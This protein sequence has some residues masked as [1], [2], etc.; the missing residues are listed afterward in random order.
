M[1]H[2]LVTG[3]SGLVGSEAV[4]FFGGLGFEVT[5]VDNNMRA[6][7]FGAGG[8]T[9]G[10]LEALRREVPGYD[11]R[12]LDVRDRDGIASLVAEKPFELL[13]HA[14]AQP[15]HDLGARIPFDDFEVNALGTLN[16][17][18][19]SRRHRPGAVFCFLS[20]NKVYGDAPNELPLMELDERYDY[21]REEDREGI[22][23]SMRI[24]RSLHSLFG[25]SK[26]SADLLVQE[27]ARNFGMKAGV[28]RCGCITGAHHAGVELHGFLSYLVRCAFTGTRYTIYGYKGKQVRDQIHAHDVCT[29]LRAFYDDPAPGVY[30]LVVCMA[31]GVSVLE[32]I[33]LLRERYG[34]IV[35]WTY[36]AAARTGDHVCYL[37]N[38][39]AFRRRYPSWDI[40]I[41]LDEIFDDLASPWTGTARGD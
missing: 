12:E 27:Y 16:L 9:T 34:R 22:D 15:S 13:V 29:A 23:E 39:A 1:P 30:N 31:N 25:V 36:D 32:A 4:R 2:A 26:A 3:S 20:T 21:A 18:E 17:L 8:D 35:E 7:F 40:S 19:A 38:L 6:R 11:H 41:S 10:N 37:T 24:D 33:R 28:F 14:A 5:G